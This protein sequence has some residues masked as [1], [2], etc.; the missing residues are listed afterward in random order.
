VTEPGP[1]PVVEVDEDESEPWP[2]MTVVRL[3]PSSKTGVLLTMP[4]IALEPP[5]KEPDPPEVG[6]V[7]DGGAEPEVLIVSN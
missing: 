1:D 6:E 4:G 5:L 2:G 7:G 3:T